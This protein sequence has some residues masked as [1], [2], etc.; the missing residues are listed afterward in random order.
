VAADYIVMAAASP[1]IANELPQAGLRFW[2]AAKFQFERDQAR[3]K[4][5]LPPKKATKP[6]D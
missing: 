6:T 3:E 1:N 5:G 4:F 2:R